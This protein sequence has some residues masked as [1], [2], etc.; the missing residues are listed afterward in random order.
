MHR[1]LPWAM[2]VLLLGTG[3]SPSAP[4]TVGSSPGSPTPIPPLAAPAD[5]T[6]LLPVAPTALVASEHR[7][8]SQ[9]PP[10]VALCPAE[11]G[12]TELNVPEP[13]VLGAPIPGGYGRPPSWT[14][15]VKGGWSNPRLLFANGVS[16][17]YRS[18]DCGES[19]QRLRLPQPELA[20]PSRSICG[21]GVEDFVV[22]ARNGI[23]ATTCHS[24]LG[25]ETYRTGPSGED[26]SRVTVGCE[27]GARRCP[28][29]WLPS[30][31]PA[32]VG[33][34]YAYSRQTWNTPSGIMRSDDHGR[35][36]QRVASG[37]QGRLLADPDDP[38]AVYALARRE[39]DGEAANL[40]K[41]STDRGMTWT[42]IPQS[43]ASPADWLPSIDWSRLWAQQGEGEF[44]VSRDWGRT[45][46]PVDPNPEIPRLTDL[47]PSPADP[48]VVI[49][50]A[51]GRAWA[52][53]DPPGDGHP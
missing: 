37:S 22:D 8:S 15:E 18:S 50:T 19:W 21:R 38:E 41:H 26:W 34:L 43:P 52:Y 48:Q 2:L 27:A 36:W 51:G 33:V 45:W 25:E 23:F 24:S 13:P 10:S 49:V 16:G 39:V 47:S 7:R 53:R 29:L 42:E 5:S 30:V 6:S 1:W 20:N 3:Y 4:P 31:S 14:F 35:T 40:L 46:E 9:A 44:R 11:A 32:Q 17:I 28:G 12:W